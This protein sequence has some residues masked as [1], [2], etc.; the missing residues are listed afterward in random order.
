MNSEVD[1]QATPC[2]PIAINTSSPMPSG[3]VG[4]AYSVQLQASGCQ[5]PFTWSLATGSQPVPPGLSLA[6]NGLLSGTPTTNGASLLL[7][8]ATDSGHN[9]TTQS[10][11]L[12]ITNAP[13]MITNNALAN[14]TQGVLYS[15]QLRTTGGQPPYSFA[16]APGSAPLPPSLALATNGALSGIPNAS[17]VFYFW[18]RVTDGAASK[19]D[20]LFSLTV[21]ASTNNPGLKLTS[22]S[23]VAN[24]QFQFS[25]NTATGVNYTI[26]ASSDLKTWISA[27]TLSG[28]GGPLS[29]TDDTAAVGARYYRVKIGQ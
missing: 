27:A 22:A 18:V 3:Q 29:F 19:F 28:S 23:F 26:Q 9:S 1:F 15:A 16:P 5:T 20:K 14:A 17:G 24:G 12:T 11:A 25:F 10:L 2:A 8:R 21:N 13:L 6:T 7:V 4:S